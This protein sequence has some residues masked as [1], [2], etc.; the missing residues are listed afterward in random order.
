MT[1]IKPLDSARLDI[2]L[3]VCDRVLAVCEKATEGPWRQH[4][5]AVFLGR[6]TN[7]ARQFAVMSDADFIV[8]SRTALPAFVAAV[9]GELRWAQ[10]SLAPTNKDSVYAQESISDIAA[11]LRPLFTPAEREAWEKEVAE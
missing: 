6:G 7:T 10:R 11:A 4:G 2:L 1:R 5:Y 3:A 9:K 8:L